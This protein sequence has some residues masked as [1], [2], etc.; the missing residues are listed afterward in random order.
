[1][2]KLEIYSFTFSIFALKASITE[3]G[4]FFLKWFE[5]C[6]FK[7]YLKWAF[8]NLDKLVS[9]WLLVFIL[10]TSFHLPKMSW[11]CRTH[12]KTWLKIGTF[13]FLHLFSNKFLNFYKNALNF[14]IEMYLNKFRYWTLNVLCN[15]ND[16]NLWTIS[17][18]VN[19]LKKLNL[20][21]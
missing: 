20:W 10:S 4:N 8:S 6:V 5:F 13:P 17:L 16:E 2:S 3:N 1:M 11:T 12:E 14:S 21:Q 9:L 7:V 15:T 19:T 18:N